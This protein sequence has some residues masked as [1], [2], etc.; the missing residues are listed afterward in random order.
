MYSNNSLRRKKKTLVSSYKQ[1]L[2]L[3]ST[4]SPTTVPETVPIVL[5]FVII[6]QEIHTRTHQFE[7]LTDK[8][9]LLFDKYV[10]T[11]IHQDGESSPLPFNP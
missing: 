8:G 6:S 2:P 3:S 4:Q 10:I 5:I 7:R 9:V 1:K 11:T